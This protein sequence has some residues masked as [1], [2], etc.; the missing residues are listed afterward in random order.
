M[1]TAVGALLVVAGGGLT[2][3]FL[4]LVRRGARSSGAGQLWFLPLAALAC[5]VAA[6]AVFVTS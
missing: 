5:F 4:V 1:S 3:V 2:L 6:S